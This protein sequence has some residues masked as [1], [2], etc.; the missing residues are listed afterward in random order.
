MLARWI[1]VPYDEVSYLCAGINHQAWF[2]EFRRGSQ[3]L[4]P[5]IRNALERDD[6]LGQEPVRGELMKSLGYFVTESSGHASEYAP[7]FRKNAAMV[8]DELVPRFRN[9][10]DHWFSFGQTGG[11]CGIAE[12]WAIRQSK[13]Y[14]I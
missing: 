8:I 12:E 2:L 1:D 4:Y 3:D 11:T 7:Y 13:R 5:L 14:A 6:I 9:P 10:E